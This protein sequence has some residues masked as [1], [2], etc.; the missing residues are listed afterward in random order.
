MFPSRL[1]ESREKMTM[2]KSMELLRASLEGII[3]WEG[4]AASSVLTT[5]LQ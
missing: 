1:S 4:N 3:T 2:K 5:H